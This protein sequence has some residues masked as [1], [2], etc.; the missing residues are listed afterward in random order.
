MKLLAI[1]T[2]HIITSQNIFSSYYLLNTA[3][4]RSFFGSLHDRFSKYPRSMPFWSIQR[5]INVE[6]KFD[7][8]NVFVQRTFNID[9]DLSTYFPLV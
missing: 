1:M 3:G 5:S 9:L 8:Q 2:L 7:L 6:K 4:L